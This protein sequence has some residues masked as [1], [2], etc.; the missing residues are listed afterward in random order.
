MNQTITDLSG[1]KNTLVDGGSGISIIIAAYNA[2]LYIER[3]LNSILQSKCNGVE[4]VVVDD[5]STD[6]T[7]TMVR[8]Y[9]KRHDGQ[10]AIKLLHQDK[11][12]G[13]GGEELW[14]QICP[15]R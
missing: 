15:I 2:E 8:D 14:T 6:N 4:V 1:L 12:G 13:I 5:G 10:I 3:C 11:G 7:F 9:Q